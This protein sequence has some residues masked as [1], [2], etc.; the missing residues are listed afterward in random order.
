[1]DRRSTARPSAI[2]VNPVNDPPSA[3]GPIAVTIVENT[4]AVIAG[5]A[6]TDPDGI[7]P[8]FAITGGADAAF[9]FVDPTS[10]AVAFNAPADFDTFADADHNNIYDVI[11][12]AQD[13]AGGAAE[14][15]LSVAVTNVGGHTIKGTNGHDKINTDKTVKG[16]KKPAGEEDRI[17]GLDGNDKLKGGGGNDV[18]IGGQ[19]ADKLTGEAGDDRLIG[20]IGDNQ[21]TGGAGR[22]VFVFPKGLKEGEATASPYPWGLSRIKDFTVGE[23]KIELEKDLFRSLKHVDYRP[24]NGNLVFDPNLKVNGDDFQF[25]TLTKHLALTDADF[26]LV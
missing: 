17:K 1:M 21:L 14:Q 15:F 22:D 3:G 25:A 8:V 26:I 9:F 5:L 13:G 16:Q 19:G 24:G 23:D 4:T 6:A 12:S 7:P 10:G 11:V 2:V 20:G 18:L